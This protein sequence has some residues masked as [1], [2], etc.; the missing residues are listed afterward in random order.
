MAARIVSTAD[1]DDGQALGGLAAHQAGGSRKLIGAGDRR[2]AER[3]TGAVGLPAQVSD[4]QHPRDA[5]RDVHGA[6]SP[7]A[8]VRVRDDHGDIGLRRGD[9]GV[10]DAARRG[11]G[12]GGQ[13]QDHLTRLARHVRA[14]HARV[15]ADPTV[16]GLH[17]ERTRT[18]A[19]N[20]PRAA[21]DHLNEARVLAHLEGQ[22]ERLRR[23]R[24]G[25]QVDEAA[26][27]LGHDFVGDDED[28]AVLEHE[29]RGVKGVEDEHDQVIARADLADAGQSVEREAVRW[30]FRS[31]G[32]RPMAAP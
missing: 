22:G 14:I 31:S 28:I 11:V 13:G 24:H 27:S 32:H 5:D 16:A 30:H 25:G 26:L 18:L 29:V 12:I 3:I 9:E 23:G 21:Q 10:A 20:G 19:D 4:R 15:G 7:C 17:D 8:S 2:D 6:Q 1:E